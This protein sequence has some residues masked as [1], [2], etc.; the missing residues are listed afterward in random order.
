MYQAYRFTSVMM[1]TVVFSC[2]SFA[3]LHL[4]LFAERIMNLNAS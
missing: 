3:F 2:R 1:T 4:Q